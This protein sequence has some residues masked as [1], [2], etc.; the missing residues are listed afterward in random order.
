VSSATTYLRQAIGP[1]D[2]FAALAIA[3]GVAKQRLNGDVEIIE[4]RRVHDASG[5]A[6]SCTFGLK[7]PPLEKKP[8]EPSAPA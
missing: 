8:P 1:D 7:Q 3:A 6:L 5:P 2:D 4:I